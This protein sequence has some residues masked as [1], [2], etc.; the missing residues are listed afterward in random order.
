MRPRFF[1]AFPLTLLLA[2]CLLLYFA[3]QRAEISWTLQ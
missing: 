1:F 2:L 3:S